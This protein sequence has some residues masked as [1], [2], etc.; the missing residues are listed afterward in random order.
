MGFRYREILR[1]PIFEGRIMTAGI[2]GI[3][4]RYRYILMTDSLMEILSVEELKAVMAHEVGH[5]KYRHMYFY[6]LFFLGYIGI[7]LGAFDLVFKFMVSQPVLMRL[8]EDSGGGGTNLFYL[9]LSLPIILSMFIY[10]RYIM[11]FFMRHFERQADLFSAVTMGSP[12]P[13]VSALEKIALLSG[14][15]RD[16]PS[17]HHFSVKERVDC[18]LRTLKDPGLIERHKK[19]VKLTFVLYLLSVLGLIYYFNFSTINKNID[20]RL[21]NNVLQLQVVE[22]PENIII[23]ESLAVTYHEMGKYREAIETYE[24]VLLLDGSRAITLNNLA[25]LLVTAPEVELRDPARSLNLAEE[26]VA[27]ERSPIFPD[28]L[29]EALYVNK[30][31]DRAIEVI[32]EAISLEN[33][34]D[35]Y[36]REQLEKFLKARN[37]S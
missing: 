7:S 12:T 19:F 1:W 4:P 26:A 23:L 13:A 25:W 24:K 32:K 28:T 30:A 14:R 37:E 31:F 35:S 17:W 34:D 8:V 27:I 9:I 22:D 10:F 29:A 18:L 3:V 11:G 21:I 5:A 16:V 33:E 36:Y 6:V 15:S 20:Y 2:M